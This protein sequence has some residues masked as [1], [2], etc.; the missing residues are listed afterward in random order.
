MKKEKMNRWGVTLVGVGLALLGRTT[1][2]RADELSDLKQALEAQKART[3]ELENRVNQIDKGTAKGN[4]KADQAGVPGILEWAAKASWY[5][6]FRYRYESIDDDRKTN[7]EDRNR[8]RVR[9]GLKAKVNDEWNLGFRIAT[10]AA[11]PVST[12]QTL[13]DSFSG[14]SLRLDLAFFDYHPLWMKGLNVQ[15]GKIL[16]PFYTV[17][18]NQL[19]WDGDL[20]LEGGAVNYLWPLNE[21]TQINVAGG[22]FW[23]DEVS[24]GA[25][26]SLWGLQGYVKHAFDTPTYVLAGAGWYD[27]GHLK[28]YTDLKS[29]WDSG[30]HDFFGNTSTSSVFAYDYDLF[31]LFGEFGTEIRG[32]PVSAFGDWVRNTLAPGSGN[33]GWL[34]GASMNKLKDP[35]SWQFSYNYRDVETDAVVGQFNDS[36]FLGGGTGGKGSQFSIGYQIAKNVQ[37]AF[38]YFLCKF[39]RPG[40]DENYNRLQADIILKF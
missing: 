23:V 22:G 38:A 33:T 6:D 18:K 2:V 15:A 5:G 24:T 3:A 28:G 29:T 7:S 1:P 35:G 14:K 8:I 12:N 27:Y 16:N 4:A 25:N 34:V 19:I 13:G 11:D 17:G 37:A 36:D 40:V 20:N 10:G 9:L 26:P 32:L 31:E 30:S 21:Q 39:D